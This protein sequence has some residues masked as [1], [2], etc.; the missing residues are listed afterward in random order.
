MGGCGVLRIPGCI[1][2]MHDSPTAW[3]CGRE[4][5]FYKASDIF[6]ARSVNRPKPDC[7]CCDNNI[8][9]KKEHTGDNNLTSKTSMTGCL[10]RGG[11]GVSRILGANHRA[12]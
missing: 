8:P 2:N 9:R 10:V 12:R 4:G 6:Y 1:V 5:V 7:R 3:G 11:C